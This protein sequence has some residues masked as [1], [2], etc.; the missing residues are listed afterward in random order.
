[1]KK[2]N[3]N[4]QQESHS[5]KDFTDILCSTNWDFS[6][7]YFSVNSLNKIYNCSM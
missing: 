6:M 2:K 4:H 3:N 1:M 5:T 7:H